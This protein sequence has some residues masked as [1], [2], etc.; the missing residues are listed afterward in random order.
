M[1]FMYALNTP[2]NYSTEFVVHTH[3]LLWTLYDLFEIFDI[4]HLC[5]ARCGHW[6]PPRMMMGGDIDRGV[7]RVQYSH[8]S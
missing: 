3:L 2:L 5:C 1:A 8:R 6:L 7:Q 4:F